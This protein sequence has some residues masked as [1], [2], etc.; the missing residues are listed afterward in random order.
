RQTLKTG[1]DLIKKEISKLKEN[2]LFDGA[3]AFKLYDTYGFP[4]DLTE[5]I[6]TENKIKL[7]QA[8]FDQAMK[9]QKETSKKAS[10]FSNQEDNVK[11]FYQIKEKNGE[12][13]FT[14]HEE[15]KSKSKLLA[16]EIQ[17]DKAFLA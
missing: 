7:D 3:Q 12:T 10:K 15:D 4:L 16:I 5:L 2:D 9:K 11:A 1:L 17:E 6:L 8:G 14:G 13:N